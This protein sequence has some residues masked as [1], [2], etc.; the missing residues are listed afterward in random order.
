MSLKTAQTMKGRIMEVCESWKFH[1]NR[2]KSKSF[3]IITYSNG[4]H[5]SGF[6]C[7]LCIDS[8]LILANVYLGVSS[9]LLKMRSA[10]ASPS[11]HS[12]SYLQNIIFTG[13]VP[14]AY[15][16]NVK[17]A[18]QSPII[19]TKIFYFWEKKLKTQN[20]PIAVK[21]TKR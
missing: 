11:R 10:C 15:N 6:T 12:K 19:F 9:C 4:N 1:T 14:D 13:Y 8:L 18:L 7:I 17:I 3:A 20:E 2:N 21:F 5:T 16:Y